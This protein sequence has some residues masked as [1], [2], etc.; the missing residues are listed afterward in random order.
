MKKHSHLP[1]RKFS[2]YWNDGKFEVISGPTLEQALITAGHSPAK[3]RNIAGFDYGDIQTK[4][5]EAQ[6]GEWTLCFTDE[7]ITA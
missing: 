6:T 7:A 4:R 1:D 3:S 2:I 5:W